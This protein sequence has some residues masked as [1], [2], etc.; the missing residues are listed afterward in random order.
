MD[1]NF[2]MRELLDRRATSDAEAML[3]GAVTAYLFTNEY[4]ELRTFI[5]SSEAQ[6]VI[7][8]MSHTRF[9]LREQMTLQATW[10]LDALRALPYM[11]YV[12][13][14]EQEYQLALRELDGP[15]AIGHYFSRRDI[16]AWVQA[17]PQLVESARQLYIEESVH[18]S[19]LHIIY[20]AQSRL[21]TDPQLHN[22]LANVAPDPRSAPVFD[23]LRF[24]C[25]LTE[26]FGVGV[27]DTKVVGSLEYRREVGKHY[28]QVVRES[29]ADSDP[30]LV[31]ECLVAWTDDARVRLQAVQGLA[32]DP[33]MAAPIVDLLNFYHFPHCAAAVESS[34]YIGTPMEDVINKLIQSIYEQRSVG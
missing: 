31:R 7:T 23:V 6:Q 19:A 25:S 13:N 11:I 28:L 18:T 30:S 12:K 29:C 33:Q 26:L 27:A 2:D 20:E 21:L 9:S 22:L 10:L 1:I 14:A 34:R 4:F 5:S 32:P 8:A 16:E 24:Y 17:N 3:Y 15:P